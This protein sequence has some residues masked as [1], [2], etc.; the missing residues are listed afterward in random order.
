MADVNKA[1]QLA[2][3]ALNSAARERKRTEEFVR[4]VGPAIVEALKPT[5]QE[6]SN[7]SRIAS[8]ELFR[9]IS[10]VKI[11]VPKADIPRA[12]VEV[13]I[14]EIRVPAPVV[15]VNVPDL[16]FPD[17][18]EIKIPTIK[19]PKPEVTVNFDAS[20]IKIPETKFPEEMEIRGWVN[21][22]GYDAGLLSNPL[23]VQLRDK[24]GKPVS[25]VENMMQIVSSGGGARIVKVSGFGTSAFAEVTNPD[26]RVRVEL[27]T[28]SSGLTDTELRATAVPVSQVSGANWSVSA[29]ATDFDIRDLINATDSISAYQVSGHR[30]SV[31][32]TQSGTW[33]VATVTSITNTVQ[34]I[35]DVVSDTAD[36]GSA[37]VKVGGIARTT[38]PTAVGDGD[39]VSSTNDDVGR[40]LIRPLQVRDLL[41]SAYVTLT[42]GTET[43]LLANA[44]AGVFH[45][46]VWVVGANQSDSAVALDIRDVTSGN[47]VMTLELPASGTAGIAPPVPYPQGNSNNNWT[48]DMSDITG[49][50]VNITALFSKEV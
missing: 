14:P 37:P 42:T 6:I 28:G 29:S 18:P 27:P 10:E 49:T 16:K 36:T 21:L 15:T 2:K 5:L 1:L 40:Q 34:A 11:D 30:W 3:E 25:L 46:L 44:G 38:N 35:G 7:N 4:S 47:V 48:V 22:M 33:D 31:E 13:K 20:R 26:G 8:E 45:D 50:T 32:A 19:V 39:R 17:F 43:T 12:E 24:D 9:A 41:A 23:P